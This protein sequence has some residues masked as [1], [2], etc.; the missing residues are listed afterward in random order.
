M[1]PQAD[2]QDSERLWHETTIQPAGVNRR[3]RRLLLTTKTLDEAMAALATIGDSIH[4]IASGMA[5]T[6]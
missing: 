4:D 2:E 1:V 3:K 5:A 6:L